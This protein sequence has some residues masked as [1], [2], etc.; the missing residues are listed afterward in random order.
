MITRNDL[1]AD[2]NI[3]GG[4]TQEQFEFIITKICLLQSEI[5]EPIQNEI[6]SYR[7]ELNNLKIQKAQ[8]ALKEQEVRKALW[9]ADDRL[10]KQNCEFYQAKKELIVLNPKEEK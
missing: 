4:L 9:D 2:F 5:A 8:L 6:S 3:R 1:R 10:R 7:E